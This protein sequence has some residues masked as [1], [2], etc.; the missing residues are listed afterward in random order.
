MR[1]AAACGSRFESKSLL[2]GAR[3]RSK[4]IQNDNKKEI[5]VEKST[6]SKHKTTY[7]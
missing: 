7:K 4:P 5:L 3:F 1:A 2:G 6:I